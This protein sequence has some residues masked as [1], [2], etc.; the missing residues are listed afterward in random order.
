MTNLL[1]HHDVVKSKMGVFFLIHSL[2]DDNKEIL[3]R[4]LCNQHYLRYNVYRLS[5]QKPQQSNSA[6][7]DNQQKVV[8]TIHQPS[9]LIDDHTDNFT[10]VSNFDE[11]K[12]ANNVGSV[13]DYVG[14]LLD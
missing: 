5:L 8:L 3:E 13:V 7:T 10:Y 12:T 6:S 4:Q 1:E 11:F 2:E 14:N 9:F